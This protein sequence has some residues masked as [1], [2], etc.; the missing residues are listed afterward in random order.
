M[1]YRTGTS[2]CR[3]RTGSLPTLDSPEKWPQDLSS[4]PQLHEVKGQTSFMSIPCPLL[5]TQYLLPSNQPHC[6]VLPIPHYL[7]VPLKLREQEVAHANPRETGRDGIRLKVVR[8]T[9]QKWSDRALAKLQVNVSAFKQNRIL[10]VL[11]SAERAQYALT[12]VFRISW[13]R[14]EPGNSDKQNL[15]AL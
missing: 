13:G 10:T 15:H 14:W 5:E 1:W 3:C 6:T 8:K 7:H 2:N 11:C 9:R 4:L 12:P